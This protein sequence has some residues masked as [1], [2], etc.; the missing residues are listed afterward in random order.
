M[1]VLN[2][3]CRC[4]L[5]VVAMT[6]LLALPLAALNAADSQPPDY[7]PNPQLPKPTSTWLP[8]IKWSVA[9]EPWPRDATPKAARRLAVAAFARDL[10][11]PR[12]LH[13]LPNGDV[14]V[15]EAATE[16]SPGWSPRR[17]FQSWVQR[18]SG[19]IAENA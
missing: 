2:C 12:W 1:Q 18:R 13:V 19:A 15:A 3:P 5:S 8:T 9:T 17:I 16:P 7:G 11:H 14:L 10:K 4:Q 6:M